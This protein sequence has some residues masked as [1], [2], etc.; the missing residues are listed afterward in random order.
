MTAIPRDSDF[1]ERCDDCEVLVPDGEGRYP[2][3]DDGRR[4]CAECA[5]ETTDTSDRSVEALGVMMGWLDELTEGDAHKVVLALRARFDRLRDLYPS[6]PESTPDMTTY[7]H[8][9]TLAFAV[10]GSK[11]ADWLDALQDPDEKPAVIAALKER[12]RL[13]ETDD[14]EYREA[15]DG[16]DTYD[17]ATW[18]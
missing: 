1:A 14:T 13:L 8:A 18:D 3:G 11:H 17:E 12:V 6:T 7:N 4:V 9:F 16:Y 2:D 5:E 10:P 15:L